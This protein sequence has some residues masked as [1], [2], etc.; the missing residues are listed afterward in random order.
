MVVDSSSSSA[1]SASGNATIKA[2]VIDV[3]GGV[4]KSGNAS[5]SP[6]PAPARPVLAD[7]LA[8]LPVPSTPAYQLRLREPGRQL[9]RDD[10]PGHLPP[11]S[12]SG[13]AKLTLNAGTYIIEGGGFSVSGNASVTG[14]GVTIV[15]AGSKYPTRRAGPTAASR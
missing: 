14:S 15:N 5:F 6:A 4:Q 11:I 8:A 1:L 3:H 12:V 9:L 10:Q 2:A 13:N 7:P